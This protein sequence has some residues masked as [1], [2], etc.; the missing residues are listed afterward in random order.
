MP[1]QDSQ[2]PGYF[3]P[4]RPARAGRASGAVVAFESASRS[5]DFAERL[6]LALRAANLSGAQLSAAVGVD[7]SVVSRWLS[8]QVQPTS[9]NLAR[10]SAAL[11]KVNPRFNMI[12]WSAPAGR[13]R[14]R[15][16]PCP[17][18]GCEN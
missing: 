12:L 16:W 4:D 3:A 8:G 1:L 17:F 13:V 15:D 9:Y 11:A 2:K 10:I 6:S 14:V 18:D 5:N 7:K